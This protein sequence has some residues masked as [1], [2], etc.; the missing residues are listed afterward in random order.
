MRIP[1]A[2]A[3]AFDDDD[4]VVALEVDLAPPRARSAAWEAAARVAEGRWGSGDR[5]M[6][7]ACGGMKAR[8]K[9]R[10]RRGARRG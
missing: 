2:F 4:V 5:G 8:R 9:T 10:E 3:F 6:P 7:I 1:F